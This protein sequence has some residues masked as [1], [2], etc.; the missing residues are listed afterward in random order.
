MENWDP[1][2]ITESAPTQPVPATLT[3]TFTPQQIVTL[4][5]RTLLQRIEHIYQTRKEGLDLVEFSRFL[6]NCITHSP[7][8]TPLLA[9]GLR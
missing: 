8:E 7:S 1:E 3:R 2:F 9:A 5:D 6:L 4:L